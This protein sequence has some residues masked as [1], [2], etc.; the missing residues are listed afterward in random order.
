MP[1]DCLKL[2]IPFLDDWDLASLSNVSKYFNEIFKT[3]FV[4]FVKGGYIFNNHGRYAVT[5][6]IVPDRTDYSFVI[7]NSW[8]ELPRPLNLID[9][10]EDRHRVTIVVKV[11]SKF[12]KDRQRWTLSCKVDA[13]AM[14]RSD[15][16]F[17][18]KLSPHN[19]FKQYHTDLHYKTHYL[20]KGCSLCS[21]KAHKRLNS[22]ETDLILVKRHLA[23]AKKY[24]DVMAIYPNDV[25]ETDIQIY[26]DKLHKLQEES[27]KLKSLGFR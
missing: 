3:S 22:I 4:Y 16:A 1:K 20:D 11:N 21:L 9:M 10:D 24:V 12:V 5:R 2:L 14:V 25:R 27:K 18:I 15:M 26:E 7:P 17:P 6:E 19:L 13:V 8:I 23:L